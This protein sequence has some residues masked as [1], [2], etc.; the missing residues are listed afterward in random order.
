[1]FLLV[2]VHPGSPEQRAIKRLCGGGCVCL[3]SIASADS[4]ADATGFVIQHKHCLFAQTGNA[5][6]VLMFVGHVPPTVGH[7][8]QL[9]STHTHGVRRRIRRIVSPMGT[10]MGKEPN[11]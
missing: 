9:C 5:F 3:C 11:P 6:P 8:Q 4:A 2:P 7:T 10:P 1:M